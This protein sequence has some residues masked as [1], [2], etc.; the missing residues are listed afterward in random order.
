MAPPCNQGQVRLSPGCCLRE[1][2]LFQ[3]DFWTG[4]DGQTGQPQKARR[5]PKRL[6]FLFPILLSF[7]L[8]SA[9][10]AREMECPPLFV[11]PPDARVGENGFSASPLSSFCAFF[12]C[13]AP[14]S[15]RAF[16]CLRH[17]LLPRE[18]HKVVARATHITVSPLCLSRV[19]AFLAIAGGRPCRR[20]T[21]PSFCPDAS[22]LFSVVVRYWYVVYHAPALQLFGSYVLCPSGSFVLSLAHPETIPILSS[23]V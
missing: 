2:G 18:T 23:L 22:S 10:R 1:P 5:P 3:R 17:D 21:C 12:S 20:L 15:S 7:F 8:S 4:R 16:S 19:T 6:S 14:L 9:W 11:A 13:V